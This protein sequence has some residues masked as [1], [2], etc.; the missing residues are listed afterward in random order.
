[1]KLAYVKMLTQADCIRYDLGR[2]NKPVSVPE[3]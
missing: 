1:M 3:W 2:R